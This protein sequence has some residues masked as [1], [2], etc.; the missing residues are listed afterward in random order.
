MPHYWDPNSTFDAVPL[1]V[2]VPTLVPVPVSVDMGDN[3][4]SKLWF[5]LFTLTM[6]SR[7]DHTPD[8]NGP[9]LR[10]RPMT[11]LLNLK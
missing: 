3:N 7:F 9:L 2:P 4:E 11:Q 8:V 5:L 10:R 6:T 1:C